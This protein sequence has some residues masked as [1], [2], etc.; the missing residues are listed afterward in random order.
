MLAR[1]NYTCQECGSGDS[2]QVHHQRY[3]GPWDEPWTTPDEDL[4]TLCDSCHEARTHLDRRMRAAAGK[5]PF[6]EAADLVAEIDAR[7]HRIDVTGEWR[8]ELSR[9]L[10]K[11]DALRAEASAVLAEFDSLEM[12]GGDR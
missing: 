2:L 4:Q 8:W 11:L 3:H 9:A 6:D 7:R 5:L 10:E 1:D 12:T